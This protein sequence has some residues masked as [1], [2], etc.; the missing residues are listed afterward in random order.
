MMDQAK[1]V[2][3]NPDTNLHYNMPKSFYIQSD[4]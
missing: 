1:K 2:G 4:S 3:I